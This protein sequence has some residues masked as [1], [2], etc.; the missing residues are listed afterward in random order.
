MAGDQAA[1]TGTAVTGEMG[2]TAA[3]GP[4]VRGP[5]AGG[6][7]AGGPAAGGAPGPRLHVP[8]YRLAAACL[9][10]I[11]AGL[12]PWTIWLGASLP[13][14]YDARQWNLVWT[15]FDGALI[16]TLAGC[17]WA[18]YGRRQALIPAAFIGGTLLT[19]DAWFDVL[20]SFGSP[21]ETVTLVT[22]FA[23]ELPLAVVLFVAATRLLRRNLQVARAPGEPAASPRRGAAGIG[24]PPG[25][26]GPTG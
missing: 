17:A 7:A 4:A 2:G 16:V 14:R 15:G 23:A 22:A 3:R 19:C 25:E 21:N 8:A 24:L 26:H 13:T 20:T 6:A 9:A 1:V 5:A 12:V 11:A 18:A 10:L